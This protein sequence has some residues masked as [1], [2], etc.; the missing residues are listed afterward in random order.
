VALGPAYSL[1]DVP[2][3]CQ[4]ERAGREAQ[5]AVEDGSPKL[6]EQGGLHGDEKGAR[7]PV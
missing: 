5:V 2:T 4:Y 6:P 7:Q 3:S 1:K